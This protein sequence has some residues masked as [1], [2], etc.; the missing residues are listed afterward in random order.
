MFKPVTFDEPVE[1][2][3]RYVEET[4]PE[5]RCSPF[6]VGIPAM[7]CRLSDAAG[8]LEGEVRIL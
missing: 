2:L 7:L 3:V 4:D 1:S 6:S 8:T 5:E